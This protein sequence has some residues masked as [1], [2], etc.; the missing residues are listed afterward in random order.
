MATA[1]RFSTA[2]RNYRHPKWRPQRNATQFAAIKRKSD[3]RGDV[4]LDTLRARNVFFVS[5][6][7][8]LSGAMAPF[9]PF[10]EHAT[11][12]MSTFALRPTCFVCRGANFSF[13]V[14]THLAE[15][16]RARSVCPAARP[17]LKC[18]IARRITALASP[19]TEAIHSPASSRSHCIC[20][21]RSTICLSKSIG[22]RG[23]SM[24]PVGSRFH[25]CQ[26]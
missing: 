4:F 19:V 8:A 20:F 12:S 6:A 14:A 10:Q 2:P 18:W 5:K 22:V 17:M 11:T 21:R 23:S 24:R 26:V 9:I 1:P 13:W 3:C 25:V 7:R 15:D 16:A